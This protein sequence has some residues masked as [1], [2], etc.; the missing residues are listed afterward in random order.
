MK[1]YSTYPRALGL[2]LYRQII[3]PVHWL[4]KKIYRSEEMQSANSTTPYDWVKLFTI[5][6]TKSGQ[7]K[8]LTSLF[9]LL[10]FM[11]Y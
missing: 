3:Y 7:S 9:G 1:G 5:T 6:E 4:G 11:A 8:A 10:Y 2:K